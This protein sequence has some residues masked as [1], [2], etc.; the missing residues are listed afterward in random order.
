MATGASAA[1]RKRDKLLQAEYLKA[2]DGAERIGA[3]KNAKTNAARSL[4][5]AGVDYSAIR[6]AMQADKLARDTNSKIPEL[7]KHKQEYNARFDKYQEQKNGKTITEYSISPESGRGLLSIVNI[8]RPE[9]YASKEEAESALAN[10]NNP[11]GLR[12]YGGER[13]IVKEWQRGP[14]TS[15]HRS[16]EATRDAYDDFSDINKKMQKTADSTGI[17][18]N[19]AQYTAIAEKIK[20]SVRRNQTIKP[21]GLLSTD[22]VSGN[23][24]QEVIS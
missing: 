6:L 5:E 21:A 1:R 15:S 10:L 12:I 2:L 17:T 22:V 7:D 13:K 20:A 18:A 14:I 24:T 16:L 8:K 19:N 4:R 3:T 11:N 9:T 23:S